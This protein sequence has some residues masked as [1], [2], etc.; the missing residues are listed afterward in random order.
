MVGL[1]DLPGG[2]VLS[3]A[4]AT[5]ADG[6][7][8]VGSAGIAGSC[9][10]FGCQTAPRAFIWDATNGLRDLN[11]VLTGLGLDLGGWV[12]RE[13]RGISAD[14]RVIVGTGTNPDG[15][16]EAWRVELTPPILRGDANCD[17]AVDFFD[18]DPFLLA[19]FDLPNYQATYCDGS[20]VAADVDCSGAIDFFDID[21]FLSCLFSTCPPCP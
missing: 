13:A 17:G 7:V 14:G 20:L 2:A 10:P 5:T 19:L 12:L 21:P 9:T 1:G 6:S 8:V 18:I 15:N 11:T 4:Y 16:F 3:A